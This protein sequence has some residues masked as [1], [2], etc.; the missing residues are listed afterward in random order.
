MVPGPAQA[1]AIAAFD[2][3]AHVE[4]QRQVYARRLS[5]M[6]DVLGE[7]LGQDVGTP[8][9]GFYLWIPV[10]DPWATTMRLAEQGGVL[11]APGDFYESA[12]HIRVALV[13]PDDRL[14]LVAERLAMTQLAA[15]E[16]V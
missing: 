6:A 4:V 5:Y 1:A 15:H 14:E 16:A 9:G 8:A 11:V 10:T 3:D 13:E 12:S 2:D 7:F